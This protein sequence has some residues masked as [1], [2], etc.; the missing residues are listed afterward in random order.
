MVIPHGFL[1]FIL[2][3]CRKTSIGY[4]EEFL[5]LLFIYLFIYLFIFM[6]SLSFLK[7]SIFLFY[8]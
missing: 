8:I 4:G 1:K 6:K 3:F 5:V 7:L 2:Y